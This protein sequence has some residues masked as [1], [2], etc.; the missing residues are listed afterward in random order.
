[1]IG[2]PFPTEAEIETMDVLNIINI[3]AIALLICL[4]K[5]NNGKMLE[6]SCGQMLLGCGACSLLFGCVISWGIACHLFAFVEAVK[7]D[8]NGLLGERMEGVVEETWK[9][10]LSAMVIG[11]VP[12]LGFICGC[13]LIFFAGGFAGLLAAAEEQERQTQR[14]QQNAQVRT[15]GA[16]QQTYPVEKIGGGNQQ[17]AVQRYE[18]PTRPRQ[19]VCILRRHSTEYHTRQ[20]FARCCH[21]IVVYSP[22]LV[23]EKVT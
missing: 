7:S 22:C 13:C 19:R 18:Q 12:V 14:S 4:Q 5:Y 8:C 16:T 11:I 9:W 17:R 3:S 21:I 2:S 1:V 23:M 15:A 6:N 10:T 20:E